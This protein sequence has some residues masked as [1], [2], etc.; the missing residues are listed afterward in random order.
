MVGQ[1]R[2]FISYA[3]SDGSDLARTLANSLRRLGFEVFLDSDSISPGEDFR[4]VIDQAIERAT[5]LVVILT[6]EGVRSRQVR[7]EWEMMVN[8][9]DGTVIPLLYIPSEIPL[10]LQA[11]QYI[12]FQ[13]PNRFEHALKQLSE[14]LTKKHSDIQEAIEHDWK[15]LPCIQFG[16]HASKSQLACVQKDVPVGKALE[17][18]KRNRYAFRH[19]LVTEDGQIGSR[20][21]GLL[22]LRTIEKYISENSTQTMFV[23]QIMDK[24][25]AEPLFRC[26]NEKDTISAAIGQFAK[27]VERYPGTQ[28]RHYMS[29]LP[30]IDDQERAVGVISFKDILNEMVKEN[31]L[32][33][34]PDMTVR[35]C[36]RRYPE[37]RVI[38]CRDEDSIPNI[39]VKMHGS[40][41]RDIPVVRNL[42]NPILEGLIND[43]TLIQY[44]MTEE[45][46]GN[47]KADVN[48][49]KLQSPGKRIAE[50]L[51]DYLGGRDAYEYY[52]LVVVDKVNT[53]TPRLQGLIGYLEIF[54]KLLQMA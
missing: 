54:R 19:L 22:S 12:D 38:V 24:Y 1:K 4:F 20:L 40:G 5:H 49:L 2:I 30:I 51:R 34:T 6:P 18:I 37:D 31:A 44:R 27:F 43:R 53:N 45:K 16:H 25:N 32:I 36:M 15:K 41:Q 23:E 13:D 47:I 21:L 8:R 7:I 26:V 3:H 33:P 35:E 9:R 52:S 39:Q 50:M 48:T 29:T 10:H 17:I 11:I 28:D 46:A 42:E 14:A